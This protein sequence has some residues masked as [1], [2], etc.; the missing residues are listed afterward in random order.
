MDQI[1][2]TWASGLMAPP[3]CNY[4]HTLMLYKR[5]YSAIVRGDRLSEETLER[6]SLIKLI[7]GSALIASMC[8]LPSVVLVLFG[9]ASVSTGA[10]LSD[11]LYWGENGYGWFRPLMLISALAFAVI[12]LII[13]FRSKG[14]C[15]LDQA[16]KERR[17]IINTSLFVLVISYL[18]YL[19]FNYVILTEIGILLDLPWEESRE[20]Y[21]FWK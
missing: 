11:T 9:L 21:K 4:G 6:K 3:Y 14:I 15:T 13:H 18:T 7:S 20:S 16:K 12:G 8:C 17:K 2:E 10:A 5:T 1:Y 19:L